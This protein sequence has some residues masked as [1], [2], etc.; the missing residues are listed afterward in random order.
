MN[1]LS[2]TSLLI[3]L[4]II[5]SACQKK[6][7]QSAVQN[8]QL[9]ILSPT[10]G[11]HL[12]SGDSLL[13]NATASYNNILHGYEIML[14]DTATKYLTYNYANHAH[15]DDIRVKE[16]VKLSVDK[17]TTYELKVLIQID[18]AGNTIQKSVFIVCEP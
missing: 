6:P 16:S 12:K 4:I 7:N 5:M 17:S 1:K 11:A 8:V 10:N 3:M 15:A 13:I 14:V 18:H 2:L 9:D